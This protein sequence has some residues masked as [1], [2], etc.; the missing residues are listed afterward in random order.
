ML[1]VKHLKGVL[2]VGI[3]ILYKGKEELFIPTI[4]DKY[5]LVNNA[6][7]SLWEKYGEM[8]VKEIY[9]END[10]NILIELS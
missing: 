10:E 1:K 3:C 9:S 4:K 2:R 7:E 5:L 8:K 6:D